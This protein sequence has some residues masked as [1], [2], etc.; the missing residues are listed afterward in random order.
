MI[1]TLNQEININNEIF[2]INI[3]SCSV[4]NAAASIEGIHL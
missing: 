1:I 2:F 4:D 3:L